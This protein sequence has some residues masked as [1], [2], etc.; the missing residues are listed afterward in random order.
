MKQI[1][2]YLADWKYLTNV[3]KETEQSYADIIKDIII[4]KNNDKKV[5]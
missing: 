4:K 5:V 3:K 1:K 2:I